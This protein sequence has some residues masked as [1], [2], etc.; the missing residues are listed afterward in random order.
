MTFPRVR[1][2]FKDWLSSP[3][4]L[5]R[6]RITLYQTRAHK[7]SDIRVQT[8]RSFFSLCLRRASGN[9]G[10]PFFTLMWET[11]LTATLI[12]PTWPAAWP[13]WS[14]DTKR[15]EHT[16]KR[17]AGTYQSLTARVHVLGLCQS[18]RAARS[19]INLKPKIAKRKTYHSQLP[20]ELP[21]G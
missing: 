11:W 4:L 15:P 14:A 21:S 5:D 13:D 1:G 19:K 12:S 20:N 16:T 3:S 18:H 6:K 9:R 7:Q 2:I 10:L 17:R 8:C